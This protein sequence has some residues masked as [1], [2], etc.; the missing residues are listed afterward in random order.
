VVNKEDVGEGNRS[1]SNIESN[2]SIKF[3]NSKPTNKSYGTYVNIS[4]QLD[5]SNDNPYPVKVKFG[6]LIYGYYNYCQEGTLNFVQS[7]SF[8]PMT[9]KVPAYRTVTSMIS[10]NVDQNPPYSC[11]GV[12]SFNKPVIIEV[13]LDE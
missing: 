3:H 11:A 10:A 7:G 5:I 4:Y 9:V 6:R 12:P 8:V 1:R 2:C 13:Q